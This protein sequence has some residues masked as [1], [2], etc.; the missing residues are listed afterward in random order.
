M[1][2]WFGKFDRISQMF[3][4]E[5]FLFKFCIC[6]FDGARSLTWASNA[7]GGNWELA[8]QSQAPKGVAG[9]HSLGP[10]LLRPSSASASIWTREP[11]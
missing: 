2:F 8:T 5:L 9:P 1:A 4:G 10:S 3:L 11:S 6:L 7:L